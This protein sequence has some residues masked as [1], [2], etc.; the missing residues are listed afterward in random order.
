MIKAA[1]IGLGKIG[2][3]YDLNHSDFILTHSKAFDQHTAFELC[4]ATSISSD[5]RK[6]FEKTYQKHS[7][8]TGKALLEESKPDV[9]SICTPTDTHFE[10]IQE[11]L[12]HPVKALLV[13]KPFTSSSQQAETLT[14]LCHKKNIP[15][16]VNYMRRAEP[17]ILNL[18][19]NLAQGLFGH[20]QN[21]HMRY[22][23]TPLNTASHFIDL[24]SF[25]FGQACDLKM[26]DHNRFDLHF[27]DIKV[28]FE[29]LSSSDTSVNEFE[30]IGTQCL[31]SYLQG[32]IIVS[33]RTRVENE[34]FPGHFHFSM[35]QI[36]KT[37]MNLNMKN[38]LDQLAISLAGKP[39]TLCTG[40]QACETLKWIEK[41]S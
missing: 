20:V 37:Q 39:S 18:K 24:F 33:E 21:V 30:I 22:T 12:K 41:L 38:V 40:R 35:P 23:G 31:Y 15:L 28:S 8:Q 34:I 5:D 27:K 19:A 13:E 36:R 1:V 3:Q 4:G 25:L 6:L 2:L 11:V 32:G 26:I 14:E 16:Y 7:Y 17:E 10:V 29:Q 9:V